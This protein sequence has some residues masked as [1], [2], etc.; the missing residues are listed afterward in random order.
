MVVIWKNPH[1]EIMQPS[2]GVT[3]ARIK[4]AETAR[5]A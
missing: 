3:N 1:A 5:A 4:A 2:T